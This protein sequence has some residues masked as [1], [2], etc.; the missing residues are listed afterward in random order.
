M[1]SLDRIEFLSLDPNLALSLNSSFKNL[2]FCELLIPI[3]AQ[4]PLVWMASIFCST[5]MHILKKDILIIFETF[6]TFW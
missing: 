3:M 6:F 2:K 5:R 1:F 4:R